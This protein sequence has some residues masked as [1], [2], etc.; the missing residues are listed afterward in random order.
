[1]WLDSINCATILGKSPP[2]HGQKVMNTIRGLVHR[3]LYLNYTKLFSQSTSAFEA[4]VE[5]VVHVDAWFRGMAYAV[6]SGAGDNAGAGSQHNGMYY[7]FPDGRV[8]FLPHD[9]DF[10]FD[11]NRSIT[12]NSECRRLTQNDTRKRIYYGTH[13]WLRG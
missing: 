11:S 6:L 10:A 7:A 13:F 12:A 9:M 1:M 3:R 5:N 4:E 8:M 2:L